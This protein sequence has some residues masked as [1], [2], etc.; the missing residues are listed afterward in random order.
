M[1]GIQPK[2]I[3]FIASAISK[4]LY[5][6]RATALRSRLDYAKVCIEVEVENEI[7]N[8]LTVDLGNEHTVEV[9]VDTPWLPAK[10]D[11]CKV[12]GHSCSSPPEAAPAESTP[13]PSEV[14]AA[15]VEE[16]PGM[17]SSSRTDG[18]KE[19]GFGDLCSAG[20]CAGKEEH[21]LEAL[22]PVNAATSSAPDENQ[23]TVLN[24]LHGDKSADP[25][26][27]VSSRSNS[28]PADLEAMEPQDDA[29]NSDDDSEVYSRQGVSRQEKSI[30]ME[31][32]KSVQKVQ[33]KRKPRTGKGGKTSKLP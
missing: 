12:F 26:K 13:P 7:P 17:A 23:M 19:A 9:L 16:K 21:G 3:S 18:I 4:P 14:P 20:E 32:G 24:D 11:Q 22:N 27:G 2:G 28:K 33:G 5:M 10:C 8:T 29:I 6:D 25:S 1:S 15:T 31:R 30:V